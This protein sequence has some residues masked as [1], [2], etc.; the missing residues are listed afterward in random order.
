M[1]HRA[2]GKAS[3]EYAKNPYISSIA[4]C[5]LLCAIFF[6]VSAFGYFEGLRYRFQGYPTYSGICAEYHKTYKGKSGG[7]RLV[8]QLDDREFG[9][10][11]EKYISHDFY[12]EI[13]EGDKLTVSYMPKQP[14]VIFRNHDILISIEKDGKEY[15]FIQNFNREAVVMDLS[16]DRCEVILGKYDGKMEGL[17]TIVLKTEKKD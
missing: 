3:K 14:A 1:A 13:Q 9:T 15:I 10:Q 2:Y 8:L 5:L 17:G 12:D 7:Y 11:L 4:C 16:L 6:F